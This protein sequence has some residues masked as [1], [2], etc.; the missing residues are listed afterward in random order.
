VAS[1]PVVAENESKAI[2]PEQEIPKRVLRSSGL[3]K[4]IEPVHCLKEQEERGRKN[5][6]EEMI[7]IP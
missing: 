1:L 6:Q 5:R 2:D 7:Q 3:T 4:R